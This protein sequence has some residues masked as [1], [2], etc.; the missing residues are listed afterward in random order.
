[1][2][3]L[4]DHSDSPDICIEFLSD[5]TC[6]T[7]NDLND[8]RSN[9]GGEL[10]SLL[11][12]ATLGEKKKTIILAWGL[13]HAAHWSARRETV[14]RP[15]IRSVNVME[16][17]G[18][19]SRL[20]CE[21]SANL[22]WGLHR[23]G[24]FLKTP[25]PFCTSWCYHNPG[26][27]VDLLWLMA[28]SSASTRVHHIICWEGQTLH[29]AERGRGRRQAMSGTGKGSGRHRDEVR[30]WKE[31]STIS[32]RRL[33]S[34][35]RKQQFSEVRRQKKQ[36]KTGFLYRWPLLFK[37][38]RIQTEWP[39]GHQSFTVNHNSSLWSPVRWAEWFKKYLAVENIFLLSCMP[40]CACVWPTSEAMSSVS[41][42][43]NTW[44]GLELLFQWR[45]K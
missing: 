40:V 43:R 31:Q 36:N 23:E 20:R 14:S 22:M 39:C 25:L 3:H 18:E 5:R 44:L 13:T 32:V 19:N 41:W 33:S 27:R 24:G 1:M 2:K 16:P 21:I 7:F 6:G 42:L 9:Y 4:K 10:S 15:I 29:P 45:P 38:A 34:F 8:P 35:I 37:S 12:S 17:V 30:E 11:L 26:P 28:S